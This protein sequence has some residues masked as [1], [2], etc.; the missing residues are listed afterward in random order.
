MCIGFKHFY[1]F[2]ALH[3]STYNHSKS[4]AFA[5]R[6]QIITRV[7]QENHNEIEKNRAT[8]QPYFNSLLK[9]S[10]LQFTMNQPEYIVYM[11]N[12]PTLTVEREFIRFD[13]LSQSIRRSGDM[14]QPQVQQKLSKKERAV[15][16]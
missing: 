6:V 9:Q 4:L 14:E 3:K 8:V 5:S 15:K 12:E 16:L 11:Y 2:N 7:Y 13:A 1:Q 10:N